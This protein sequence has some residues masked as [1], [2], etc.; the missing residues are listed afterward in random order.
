VPRPLPIPNPE[1][2][3]G[4]VPLET[5]PL[6]IKYEKQCPYCSKVVRGINSSILEINYAL[7]KKWHEIQ[8]AELAKKSLEMEKKQ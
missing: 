4:Y 5:K 7:H 2:D 3:E 8:I 6:K 1:E